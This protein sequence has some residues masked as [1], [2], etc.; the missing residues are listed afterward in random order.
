MD[1]LHYFN[2]YGLQKGIF[3]NLED[4]EDNEV[5]YLIN[6]LTGIFQEALLKLR[7]YLKEEEFLDKK[8][9]GLKVDDIVTTEIKRHTNQRIG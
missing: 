4:L 5:S 2:K 6:N 8:V 9:R 3:R 1:I 7:D